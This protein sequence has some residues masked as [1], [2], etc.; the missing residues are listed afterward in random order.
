MRKL[1][2]DAVL[3][4]GPQ[5]P[6]ETGGTSQ[7]VLATAHPNLPSQVSSLTSSPLLHEVSQLPGHLPTQLVLPRTGLPGALPCMG[8]RF[9]SPSIHIPDS[10]FPNFK[11]HCFLKNIGSFE[12]HAICLSPLSPRLGLICRPLSCFSLQVSTPLQLT[13]HVSLL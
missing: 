7:I 10:R 1:S 4:R 6:G 2:T 3:A 11:P 9:V 5:L 13:L 8:C 12:A